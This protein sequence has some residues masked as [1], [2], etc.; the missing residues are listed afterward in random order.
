M[1]SWA[2]WNGGQPIESRLF[3]RLVMI[4]QRDVE[5]SEEG[6]LR[7][8]GSLELWFWK[9]FVAAYALRTAPADTKELLRDTP[10][11]KCET[12]CRSYSLEQS[13]AHR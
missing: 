11:T 13:H 12:R 7:D 6:M 9:V 1:V 2:L 8:A 10:E 5:Q 4:L 3:R